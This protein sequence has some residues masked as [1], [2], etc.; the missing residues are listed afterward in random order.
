[1]RTIIKPGFGSRAVGAKAASF[2]HSFGGGQ[3][4][5][6]TR[7]R[8]TKGAVHLLFRFNLRDPA[9]PI[10]WNGPKWLPLFYC[11]QYDGCPIG[12]KVISNWQIE[13]LELDYSRYTKDFP[14]Q[15]Y[16]E[17]F[18]EV[19]VSLKPIRYE[20]QRAE[21]FANHLRQHGVYKGV[22]KGR[23]EAIVESVGLEFT[24]IGGLHD[25][26]QDLT[27][28]KCPDRQ[29]ANHKSAFGMQ[30]F[31]TIWNEP[32]KGIDIWQSQG[33]PILIVYQICTRCG[34]IYALNQCT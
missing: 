31:A 13:I 6:G 27:S 11:F 14:Y 7:P 5:R 22:L 3:N 19:P 32:L 25:L 12:Y 30:V 8:K 9:A 21:V 20:E 17:Y 28:T 29:C 15:D 23:D 10:R 24:K 26:L 1:M 34:A 33:E 18:R 16:P 2:G 4:Y